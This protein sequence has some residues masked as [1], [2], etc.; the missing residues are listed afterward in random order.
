M[1]NPCIT[2]ALIPRIYSPYTVTRVNDVSQ[3]LACMRH[4]YPTIYFNFNFN[5]F[6]SIR[7]R[8]ITTT[9]YRILNIMPRFLI[10]LVSFQFLF[11]LSFDLLLP[12]KPTGDGTI[13]SSNMFPK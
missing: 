8:K 1:Y 4:E 13:N 6:N 11:E 3:P 7:Y 10:L 12:Q 2:Y 9:I 5:S